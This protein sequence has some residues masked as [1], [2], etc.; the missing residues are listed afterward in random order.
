MRNEID[1]FKK[2]TNLNFSLFAPAAEYV[3]GRFPE[4]DKV[5]FNNK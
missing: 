3:S 2:Q 5:K 1:K 4:I